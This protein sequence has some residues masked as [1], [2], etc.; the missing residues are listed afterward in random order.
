MLKKGLSLDEASAVLMFID[1]DG[2]AK[3][4]MYHF[5]DNVCKQQGSLV[6]KSFISPYPGDDHEFE[7]SCL[8]LC[9]SEIVTC[10]S[11]G[12]QEE[13]DG[14]C[15]SPCKKVQSHSVAAA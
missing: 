13:C 11:L 6:F 7:E 14:I 4:V 12:M 8:T 5:G 15:H 2:S 9:D 1:L 3:N 10:P